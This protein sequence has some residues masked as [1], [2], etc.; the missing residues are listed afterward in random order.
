M[1]KKND[2][3]ETE[4]KSNWQGASKRSIEKGRNRCFALCLILGC[5]YI[6]RYI[7]FYIIC[8]S[9]S[10]LKLKNGSSCVSTY[11]AKI[12]KSLNFTI[13]DFSFYYSHCTWFFRHFFRFRFIKMSLLLV[14]ATLDHR[15]VKLLLKCVK[16]AVMVE[17]VANFLFWFVSVKLALFR[18]QIV[19]KYWKLR[20]N[21]FCWSETVFMDWRSVPF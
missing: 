19:C 21:M 7:L 5:R 20:W 17:F 10:D 2:K 15:V 6:L 3:K 9:D 1:R 4:G 16:L 13:I 11:T 8:L 12:S 18:K 14:Y